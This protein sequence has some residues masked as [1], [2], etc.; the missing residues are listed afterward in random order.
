MADAASI[1]ET[2]SFFAA[3]ISIIFGVWYERVAAVISAKLPTQ[4]RDRGPYVDALSRAG[5][6]KV[7]PLVAFLIGYLVIFGG[8]FLNLLFERDLADFYGGSEGVDVNASI[9]CLIFVV[10]AYLASV[11]VVQGGAIVT[12]LV[13]AARGKPEGTP[14][15]RRIV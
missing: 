8:R 1:A 6:T 7:V 11:M 2:S 14:R 15:I 10:I 13:K 12:R 5:I 9:F 4:Y 3:A